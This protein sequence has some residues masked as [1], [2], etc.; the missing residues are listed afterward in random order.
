[1]ESLPMPVKLVAATAILFAIVASF[2]K[3]PETSVI[4]NENG[5]NVTAIKDKPVTG[6]ASSKI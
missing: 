1:M 2:P 4:N 5:I 3:G 6:L